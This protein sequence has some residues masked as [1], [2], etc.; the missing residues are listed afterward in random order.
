MSDF[1]GLYDVRDTVD[2][3][4]NFILATFL[5]GLY[6]GESWFSA[7]PKH[8]FMQNYKKIAEAI[9]NSP[10]TIVKI[11]CLKEDPNVILGY[12]ILSAD[13]STIHWVYC[14]TV[15]RRRGV[16]RSLCPAYPATV[17]HLSALGKQLMIKLPNTVFNPFITP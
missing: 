6:Y 13:Y 4:R 12:S 7:I 8:I 16:A 15:W 14:K 3:D 2:S 11:A 5:R 10:N 17:S 9:L 1:R